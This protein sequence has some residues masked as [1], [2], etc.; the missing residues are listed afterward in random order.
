MPVL[1][2]TAL[3]VGALHL[4][5]LWQ[6]DHQATYLSLKHHH[7]KL[8]DHYYQILLQQ[9]VRYYDIQVKA[10]FEEEMPMFA[11][12]ITN[13]DYELFAN[14]E[15][16]V[17]L[18]SHLVGQM[19]ESGCCRCDTIITPGGSDVGVGVLQVLHYRHTW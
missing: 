10:I 18:S 19:L 5:L 3:D 13:E 1:L 15:V 11:P 16:G 8:Y 12:I 6:H 7:L 9:V 2:Q 14:K 4:A 17:T